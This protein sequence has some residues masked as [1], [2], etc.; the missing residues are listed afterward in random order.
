MMEQETFGFYESL[1]DWRDELDGLPAYDNEVQPEPEIRATFKFRNK[2]DYEKFKEKVREHL[3]DGQKVFDG[4]QR[5]TEKQAWY[6]LKEK[7]YKLEWVCTEPVNPKYPVYIVSKGRWE[8]NPT[9]KALK[10]MGV[11]FYMVVEKDE[12]CNYKTLVDESQLL[13]L[14]QSYKD[15]Y[16]VFWKDTDNRT[17]A[18]AARNFAWAHSIANG[19]EWHW[20]MDDNLEAFERFNNNRKIPVA[21]GT[22]FRIVE[23]F[24]NRYTNIAQSGLGYSHFCPANE[25][26][27]AV[28]F[29]TRIYSCL[30]IKNDIPYR[31][32]GRYNEDTDLSLRIL[33]DGLCT[34][35]FNMFLQSKRA[36]QT[37]RGGNTEEFYAGE[38]TYNKSKMLVDM[39][40]D[41]TSL[42]TKFNRDHH[43]VDY[44]RFKINKLRKKSEY[45]VKEYTFELRERE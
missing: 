39:H 14:P 10:R 25:C 5:E 15:D 12:Y 3:Y 41:V 28:R 45:L 11:P 26:R 36:T 1:N 8:R 43:H 19:H 35:E 22:C 13:I 33:K 6:P 18:G 29:N 23:D 32:R 34:A 40:P 31:W 4:L 24:V 21:D 42:T 30:L 27:P 9:S 16:D 17:G 2:E 20:V 44:R 37:V 38:G 7:D